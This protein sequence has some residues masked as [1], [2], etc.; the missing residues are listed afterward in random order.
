MVCVR[1]GWEH[2]GTLRNTSEIKFFAQTVFR[3]GYLPYKG[4][5]QAVLDENIGNSERERAESEHEGREGAF[6]EIG[7]AAVVVVVVVTVVQTVVVVV[8]VTVIQDREKVPQGHR[9]PPAGIEWRPRNLRDFRLQSSTE[10][11]L[12]REIH[13]PTDS[14]AHAYTR[15]C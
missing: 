13:P 2:F 1:L 3:C 11:T 14:H 4:M 12:R 15:V 5:S 10:P 6:A 7:A 8:V 9:F